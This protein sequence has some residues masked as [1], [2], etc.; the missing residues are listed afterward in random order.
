MKATS[1]Y[2]HGTFRKFDPIPN[3]KTDVNNHGPFSFDNI[4]MNYDYPEAS[5]ERRAEIIK[6]HE[7]YQK[8]LL[9]FYANDLRVPEEIRKEMKLWGL[10]KD[11]FTDN[12]NWPHQLYIREARRMIGEFQQAIHQVLSSVYELEFSEHSYG[13]RPHKNTRQAVHQALR[14]IN[15]GYQDIIDLDLKSSEGTVCQIASRI[16]SLFIKGL[17]NSSILNME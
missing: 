3:L 1:V 13:F 14:Y 15:A 2:R 17:E 9:Y 7:N 5:Y 8:G 6:E 4:G 12:D 10:A 11:E 16:A